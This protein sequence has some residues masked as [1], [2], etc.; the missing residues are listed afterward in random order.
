MIFRINRK[1]KN[2]TLKSLDLAK[3]NAYRNKRWFFGLIEKLRPEYLDINQNK[4]NHEDKE[5]FRKWVSE[6]IL[7]K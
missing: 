7:K 6:L 1:I 5:T 4:M 2:S 3:K